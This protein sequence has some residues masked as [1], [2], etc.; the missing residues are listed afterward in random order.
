M[1]K[2]LVREVNAREQRE[3][4]QVILLA[5]KHCRWERQVCIT[6]SKQGQAERMNAYFLLHHRY[7]FIIHIVSIF[8]STTNMMIISIFSF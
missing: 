7:T 6:L 8:T 1:L 3:A 2:G 4:D 5:Q